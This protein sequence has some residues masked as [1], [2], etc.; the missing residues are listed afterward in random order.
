MFYY[1]VYVLYI[2][3]QLLDTLKTYDYD[4]STVLTVY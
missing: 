4:W 2:I 1:I 3:K